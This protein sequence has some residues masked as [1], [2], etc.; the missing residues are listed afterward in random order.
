MNQIFQMEPQASVALIMDDPDAM[1]VV[2]KVWVHWLACN[3]LHNI[4]INVKWNL[5]IESG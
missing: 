3:I 5:Q 1:G 2:G 4:D